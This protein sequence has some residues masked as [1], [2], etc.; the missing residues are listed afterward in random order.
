MA[1]REVLASPV[2]AEFPTYVDSRPVLWALAYGTLLFEL[3][4]PLAIWWRR[5]RPWLIAAGVAFHV[6]IDLSM[7]IPIFSPR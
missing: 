4:F 5:Y 3:A 1:L 6:G 2:F 7:V